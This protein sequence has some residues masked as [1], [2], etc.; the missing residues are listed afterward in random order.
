MNFY[1]IFH[2]TDYSKFLIRSLV[3]ALSG[4]CLAG[5]RAAGLVRK[6]PIWVGP[7]I[8][9]FCAFKKYFIRLTKICSL[10]ILFL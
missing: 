10:T 4:P 6:R 1:F 7:L 2:T 5:K 8:F 3:L 9:V